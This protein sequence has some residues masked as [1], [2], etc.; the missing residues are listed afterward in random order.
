MKFNWEPGILWNLDIH[1][2]PVVDTCWYHVACFIVLIC[3]GILDLWHKN[4]VVLR[5]PS[6]ASA[7]NVE[8]S[9][10]M[11]TPQSTLPTWQSYAAKVRKQLETIGN[12]DGKWMAFWCVQRMDKMSSTDFYRAY[13][14][15]FFG[16]LR[17][18]QSKS[19]TS[20][21]SKGNWDSE[22]SQRQSDGVGWAI[23]ELPSEVPCQSWKTQGAENTTPPANVATFNQAIFPCLFYQNVKDT[24]FVDGFSQTCWSPNLGFC[25]LDRKSVV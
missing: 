25:V 6:I 1:G 3:N 21:K 16:T 13:I 19:N 10:Y 2:Y 9:N 14:T 18:F 20:K 7:C 22:I 24:F 11:E 17:H 23:F 5:V 8:R 15:V 4:T 12:E